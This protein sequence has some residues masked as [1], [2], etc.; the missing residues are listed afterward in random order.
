[1]PLNAITFDLWD[2][3]ILDG[4]DE[5]KRAARGLQSKHEE[6]RFL[7][8]SKLKNLASIDKSIT[9]AAFDVHEAA[10]RQVWYRM[11]VTWEVPERLEVLLAGL[12]IKLP[13]ATYDEL[14]H[15]FE[16]M[17]LVVKPDLISGA[18][19]TIAELADRYDL[20][21]VSDTIYTPGRGLRALLEHHDVAKHFKGFIFSDEV[22]RSKP[23]PDCFRGAAEQLGLDLSKMLHIGDRDAKDIVGAQA[24]GMKAILFTGARDEGSREITSADAVID[25]FSDLV[26]AID[27]I[28]AI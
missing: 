3:I 13:K 28:A 7:F 21:I 10:F 24:V 26:S 19:E 23:H 12:D 6:R 4:S 8:W 15:Q 1:M 11:S 22:G 16:T 9:D 2:T 27:K 14:V 18:A 17:E 25:N 5:P 20:C